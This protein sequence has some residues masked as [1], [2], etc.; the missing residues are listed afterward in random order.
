MFDPRVISS[1]IKAYMTFMSITGYTGH[2]GH[3]PLHCENVLEEIKT[4]KKLKV[5]IFRSPVLRS[6]HMSVPSPRVSSES[7][8][9]THVLGRC[10][11]SVSALLAL[12]HVESAAFLPGPGVSVCVTTDLSAR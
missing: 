3:T 8:N 2:T 6:T 10:S 4:L 12:C 9:R 1:F 7:L 5:V 11:D